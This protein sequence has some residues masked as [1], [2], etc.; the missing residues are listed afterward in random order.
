MGCGACACVTKSVTKS[1]R[2]VDA[3]ARSWWHAR[4]QLL[5]LRCYIRRFLSQRAWL[6]SQLYYSFHHDVA[7]SSLVTSLP[8]GRGPYARRFVQIPP[9]TP[10][11]AACSAASQRQALGLAVT[12]ARAPPPAARALSDARLAAR[13]CMLVRAGRLGRG[14]N[15]G[16]VTSS[17]HTRC[18][19][20]LSCGAAFSQAWMSISYILAHWA[21]SSVIGSG[22][23][24]LV[25]TLTCVP[26]TWS[27]R[28]SSS[29]AGSEH[30]C[31]GTGFPAWSGAASRGAPRE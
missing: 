23:V 24:Q 25:L 20:M 31:N 18:V 21:S 13:P 22:L 7:R 9:P 4:A 14:C 17:S 12:L 28:A 26:P 11:S 29:A 19:T 2:Q 15:S 27:R 5:A 16:A 1:A 30:G 6:A 8:L 3:V 10:R